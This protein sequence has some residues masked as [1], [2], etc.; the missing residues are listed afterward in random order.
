MT[1]KSARYYVYYKGVIQYEK[2]RKNADGSLMKQSTT[3]RSYCFD[4]QEIVKA[5]DINLEKA[6]LDAVNDTL[7]DLEDKVPQP[8]QSEL[9]FGE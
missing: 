9:D 4:Y 3:Q 7:D 8:K 5:F 6:R 2:D 1:Q